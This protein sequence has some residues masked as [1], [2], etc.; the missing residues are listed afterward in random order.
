MLINELHVHTTNLETNLS[1]SKTQDVIFFFV[2]SPEICA[3]LCK[4]DEVCS[5]N[6]QSSLLLK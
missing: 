2:A 4:A 5:L 6:F 3:A 1:F